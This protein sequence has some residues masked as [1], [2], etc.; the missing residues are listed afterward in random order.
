MMSTAAAGA[1]LWQ[2]N[3]LRLFLSHVARHRVAV[4]H[5]KRELDY[6]GISSF[7]AHEDIVPSL[8]WQAE[9]GVAIRSMQAMAALLTPEFHRSKWTDQEVGMAIASG[10]LLVPIRLGLAPYAFMAKSQALP[11][12]LAKPKE[13]ASAIATVLAKNPSTGDPMAEALVCAVEG[14]NSYLGAMAAAAVIDK[15]PR[16][17]RSQLRRLEA[18]VNVNSQVRDAFGVPAKITRIVTRHRQASNR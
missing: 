6:L 7:V 11:G 5:L 18:A 14:A 16:L 3:Q 1:Y 9:I 2:P 4:S 15:A 10:V 17:T 12:N 13:L 8:E